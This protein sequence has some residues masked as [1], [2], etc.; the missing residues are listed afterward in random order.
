[1]ALTV[2]WK[3]YVFYSTGDAILHG[4]K[5]SYNLVKLRMKIRKAQEVIDSKSAAVQKEVSLLA[6]I[7]WFSHPTARAWRIAPA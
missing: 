3:I 5:R 7:R 4:A 1:M 2:L 6:W